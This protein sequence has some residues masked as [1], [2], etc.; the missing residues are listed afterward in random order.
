MR[1]EDG[2]MWREKCGYVRQL[3]VERMNL[4]SCLH[5][6]NFTI[7]VKTVSSSLLDAELPVSDL[8]HGSYFKL[9]PCLQCKNS[10]IRVARP[11]G[12]NN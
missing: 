3:R 12:W 1:T 8:P 6:I 4:L 9:K 7:H 10:F 2:K 11:G 5:P